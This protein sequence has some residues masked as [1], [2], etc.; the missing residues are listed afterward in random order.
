MSEPDS[1]PESKAGG[2]GR[3]PAGPVFIELEAGA[4]P[5]DVGAAD[6]ID[7]VA[8]PQGR[9][10][11]MAMTGLVRGGPSGLAAL[12][13][14]AAAGL[15]LMALGLAAWDL[16]QGLLARFPAL[17]WL[18]AGLAGVLAAGLSLAV[19]RELAGY[20]R[21]RRLDWLRQ[22]AD[23]A[24]QAQDLEGARA[25]MRTLGR[26]YGEPGPATEVALAEALD[27]RA[28]I[29]GA[30]ARLLLVLDGQARAEV[31]ASA[32]QVAMIT[33][34][35]PLA[36]A[37][38]AA[39]LICNLRMIR[40]IATLY[41][42]RAGMIG[43]WRLARAVVGHLLATGALA[44]GDD[45]LGTLAGGGVLSRV[46]RRFG[47]G[48]LNGALTARVGLAALEICRPLPFVLGQRP[49]LSAVVGRALRGAFVRD[50]Q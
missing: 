13:W 47:E 20:R 49:A 38:V 2:N 36:L 8:P 39:A 26:L 9:A 14:G 43:N 29:E 35:V 7:A 42:V 46:S 15:V 6:P 4:P 31:E 48:V 44:V 50:P 24:L 34:L 45:M 21:L 32:R 40:R 12:F 11:H 28:L 22:R 1:E 27:V 23:A 10:M 5:P 37:D 16:V 25:V 3:K 30:E 33:A 19:L 41:G 17:G 18:A